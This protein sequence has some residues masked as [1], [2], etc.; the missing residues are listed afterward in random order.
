MRASRS[1]AAA[2]AVLAAL[3]LAG[4]ALAGVALPASQAG[5]YCIN[6]NTDTCSVGTFTSLGL[7]GMGFMGAFEGTMTMTI[8]GPGAFHQFICRGILVTGTVIDPDPNVI[9][10]VCDHVGTFPPAGIPLTM[11]CDTEGTGVVL[12]SV[13]GP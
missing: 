3:L 2:A 6:F 13:N 7:Y 9:F 1:F 4:P 11:R 10:G 8:E 12:C 5:L